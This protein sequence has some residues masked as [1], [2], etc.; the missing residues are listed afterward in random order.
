M[1]LALLV[2]DRV[3]CLLGFAKLSTVFVGIFNEVIAD[4][5]QQSN[6]QI[7]LGNHEALTRRHRVSIR[8]RETRFVSQ[9]ITPL[10]DLVSQFGYCL[11]H[12]ASKYSIPHE[13]VA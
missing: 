12:V 13:V 11:S 9:I 4:H 8:V 5:F 7:V 6:N 3:Y 10:G 2:K 1:T